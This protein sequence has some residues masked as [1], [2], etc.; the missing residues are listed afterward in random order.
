MA[1]ASIQELNQKISEQMLEKSMTKEDPKE[2]VF[3][4]YEQYQNSGEKV[5]VSFDACDTEG[6]FTKYEN[7]V[8][9]ILPGESVSSV[10]KHINVY[11]TARMLGISL[12]LKIKEVDRENDR[13][14]CEM[15]ELV[16]MHETIRGA[17][18]K[19]IFRTLAAGEKPLVWGKITKVTPR[20]AIVSI[21]NQGVLGIIDVTRWQKCYTRQLIGMCEVGDFFQFEIISQAPKLQ[22]KPV[23]WKLSRKDITEDAW[24]LIDY[25]SLKQGGSIL[26]KCIERPKGKNYWWGTSERTPGIEIMGDYTMRFQSGKTLIEGITYM[27][28]IDNIEIHKDEYTSNKLSVIP[29]GVVPEDAPKLSNYKQLMKN[30]LQRSDTADG[31]TED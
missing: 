22:D 8:L 10:K 18:Q 11:S 1:K 4:K 7:D 6:T 23:A 16:T 2:V 21:L 28:K 13:V 20:R 15:P 9:I 3:K 31:T 29:F 26:V 14:Y 25:E 24:S 19:E 27:C 17:I 12:K 5:E 30:T